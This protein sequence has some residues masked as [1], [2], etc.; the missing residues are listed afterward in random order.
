AFEEKVVQM[1]LERRIKEFHQTAQTL[2]TAKGVLEEALKKYKEAATR[3]EKP[4][5]IEEASPTYRKALEE[6][7]AIQQTWLTD[8]RDIFPYVPELETKIRALTQEV[9]EVEFDKTKLQFEAKIHKVERYKKILEA[10]KNKEITSLKIQEE[11]ARKVAALEESARPKL[12][13]E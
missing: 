13:Q 10:V 9:D 11:A 5:I 8:V 7:G 3:A 1:L 12:D 6:E 2:A 4:A